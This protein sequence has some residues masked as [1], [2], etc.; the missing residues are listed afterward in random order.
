MARAASIPPRSRACTVAPE[1][2]REWVRRV[3]ADNDEAQRLHREGPVHPM[4]RLQFA[5]S[6]ERT[7]RERGEVIEAPVIAFGWQL[8]CPLA[9][10]SRAHAGLVAVGGSSAWRRGQSQS[11]CGGR[12]RA[13]TLNAAATISNALL[14]R[15]WVYAGSDG[16]D[17]KTFER[18]DDD[19]FEADVHHAH[20]VV[21]RWLVKEPD[22]PRRR[23]RPCIWVQAVPNLL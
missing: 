14:A 17:L 7:A 9:S 10:G 11:T 13:S 4:A 2:T 15:G 21:G 1:P 6:P 20:R 22:K 3:E 23:A 8:S 12:P 5:E 18:E 16:D 19:V